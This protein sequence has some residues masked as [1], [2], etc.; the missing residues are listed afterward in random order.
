MKILFFL[1][2][3][4]LILLA[5]AVWG[6]FWMV[7]HRQFDDLETEGWRILSED[8]EEKRSPHE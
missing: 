4:S 8:N 7:R 3:L 2:P 5:I 6:F 1:I